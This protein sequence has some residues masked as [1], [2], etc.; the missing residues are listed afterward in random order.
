MLKAGLRCGHRLTDAKSKTVYSV[1]GSAFKP[2]FYQTPERAVKANAR[3][4][5]HHRFLKHESVRFAPYEVMY[6]PES[7]LVIRRMYQPIP[8]STN[9]IPPR[10][11]SLRAK[12]GLVPAIT[13]AAGACV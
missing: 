8:V 6:M 1:K 7:M 3:M 13:A 10:R 9:R 4:Y 5:E 12:H 2:V 11:L